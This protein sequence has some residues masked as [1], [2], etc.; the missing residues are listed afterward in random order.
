MNRYEQLYTVLMSIQDD[1]RKFYESDNKAAGVR[2]R[3][4]MLE[5]RRLSQDIRKEVQDLKNA[6]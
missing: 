5:L 4:S 2:V 3:K 1:F 6:M